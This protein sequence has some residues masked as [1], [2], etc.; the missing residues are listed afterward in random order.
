MRSSLA[1][2]VTSEV[3]RR[4]V[5]DRLAEA[6]REAEETRLA[7]AGRPAAGIM[8]TGWPA[9]D[10]AIGG[11]RFGAIHE[12]VG[13]EGA[14]GA[15]PWLPPLG[16]VSALAWRALDADRS[17]DAARI[18]WI[19]RTCWPYP[20]CLIRGPSGNDRALLARSLMV[21]PPDAASRLWAI[22][23][24]LRSPGV[25]AVIADASGLDVRASRRLQLAAEASGSLGLLARPPGEAG[26]LSAAVTRWGVSWDQ[27]SPG[28]ASA[29]WA[30]TLLRCKGSRRAPGMEGLTFSLERSGEQSGLDLAADV[31]GGPATAAAAPG[32]RRLIA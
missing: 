13:I 11:L 14:S 26:A 15:H 20:R 28:A 3:A 10:G 6:L 19:G 30:V 18:V 25:A 24:A 4:R 29:R 21:D 2:S 23:L 5:I 17:S 12:W 22:D 16:T 1:V 32:G 7:G 9:A 8:P 31:V 27:P